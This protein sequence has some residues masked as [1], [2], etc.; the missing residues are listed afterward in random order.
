M[1]TPPSNESIHGPISPTQEEE[2]EINNFPFHILDDT[3][4]YDS[5]GEE[6]SESLG[7]LN[8]SCYD[9]G[10][11]MVDNIDEFIHVG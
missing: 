5:E 2:N 1:C 7:V 4:F 10:N 9:K 8:P 3:L 11:F 6:V